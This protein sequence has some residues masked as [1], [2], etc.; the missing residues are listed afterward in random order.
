MFEA[1]PG[2]SAHLQVRLEQLAAG[3][4]AQNGL[5]PG[6]PEAVTLLGPRTSAL[7]FPAPRAVGQGR[8][9]D[10]SRDELA[11][12]VG[13]LIDLGYPA[14]RSPDPTKDS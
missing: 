7:L 3:L 12:L 4:L 1:Q 11:A 9:A 10:P 14:D 8:P 5:A 2:F 13:R 6:S